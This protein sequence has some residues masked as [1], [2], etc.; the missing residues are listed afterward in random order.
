MFWA[1]APIAVKIDIFAQEL[2]RVQGA[3]LKTL[4]LFGLHEFD[5]VLVDFDGGVDGSE[6]DQE[7][8]LAL[9]LLF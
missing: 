8:E 4:L 9:F 5:V 2:R 7:L 1:V 3:L 6:V